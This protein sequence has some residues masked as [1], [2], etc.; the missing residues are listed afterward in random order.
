MNNPEEKIWL[1]GLLKVEGVGPVIARQLIAHCGSAEEVFKKPIGHL[2]NIE[3]IGDKK[4]AAIK[5]GI[6]LV[7]AEKEVRYCLDNDIQITAYYEKSYPEKLKAIYDAPL[8]LFQKGGLVLNSRPSIAIVGTRKPTPY[9][10]ELTEIFA[11]CFA[12]AG[13]NVISGL[14]YGIDYTAHKTVIETGGITTACLGHGLN[15][16]YPAAHTPMAKQII[17]Q[18]GCLL[19]EYPSGTQPDM[20]HFPARNRIIAGLS[21]AVVIIEAAQKS[22]TLTTA[23]L[24][25]EQN[26]EVYAVPGRLTDPSYEG[27]NRLI[28]DQIAKLVT[29][30]LEVIEDILP[31][32]PGWNPVG[33]DGRT[34]RQG[35]LFLPITEP[36]TPGEQRI[37]NALEQHNHQTID[38][39]IEHSGL[40]VGQL[41]PHLSTLEFYGYVRCNPGP[42]YSRV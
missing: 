10:K 8:V 12:A 26:R 18:G 14:A 3:K 15:M 11:S 22:G 42:T 38:Q 37:L 25:F 27:C 24:A 28:R 30:P 23:R 5:R 1:L 32:I 29:E 16:I 39:L 31:Q 7:E 33:G 9:G 19:S 34:E 41:L 2:K 35:T 13:F 36:L 20:M 40:P 21:T 6:S 4:A 17:E